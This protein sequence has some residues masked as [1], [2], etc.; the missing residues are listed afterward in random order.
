MTSRIAN[1]RNDVADIE[2]GEWTMPKAVTYL[3]KESGRVE[4]TETGA[5]RLAAELSL[6]LALSHAAAY[7]RD[8]DNAT[9]E[10]PG[11]VVPT[12]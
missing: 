11:C 7:L 2:V 10:L 3:H 12:P 6:P 5:E 8:V 1:W 4:L 9:P